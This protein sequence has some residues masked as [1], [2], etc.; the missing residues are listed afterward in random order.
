MAERTYRLRDNM[1]DSYMKLCFAFANFHITIMPFR[2]D[3]GNIERNYYQ[4][5]IQQYKEAVKK[6]KARQDKSRRREKARRTL[7]CATN[8][9]NGSVSDLDSSDMEGMDES[10]NDQQDNE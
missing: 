4:R 6:R 10:K 1:Y 2:E 9:S 8:E 7:T 3:D 5:I